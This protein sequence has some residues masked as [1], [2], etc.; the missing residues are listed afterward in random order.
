MEKICPKCKLLKD[1]SLFN[2]QK[3]YCLTCHK[4]NSRRWRNLN[5]L[6]NKASNDK[7]NIKHKINDS[8]TIKCYDCKCDKIAT[9]FNWKIKDKGIRSRRCKTCDSQKRKEFYSKNKD[10]TY[11][12]IKERAKDRG[13][14]IAHFIHNY[15]LNNPC[16][17]CGEKNVLKLT[18]HHINSEDKLFNISEARNG[19]V[20]I[21]RLK[22]EISK[23][24]SLCASCH[25]EKTAIDKNYI[26]YRIYKGEI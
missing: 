20:S 15:F 10:R 18:F 12:K 23:C 17:I 14:T 6:R 1:L 13:L 5:P 19:S 16:K 8:D 3:K 25:Q 26:S 11:K 24:E 22:E 4:E 2:S 7:Y 21:K 9:E